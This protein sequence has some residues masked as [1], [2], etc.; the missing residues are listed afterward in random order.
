MKFFITFIL[1][2]ST[3][4]NHSQAQPIDPTTYPDVVI[5]P[6]PLI[7]LRSLQTGA[8]ISTESFAITDPRQFQWELVDVKA[9]AFEALRAG[10]SL[11][12]FRIRNTNVCFSFSQNTSCND[13]LRTTFSMIP[14]DTGA[15]ILREMELGFCLSSRQSGDYNIHPCNLKE[16]ILPLSDLWIVAPPFGEARLLTPSI[17]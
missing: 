7:T 2:I 11:V 15:V 16:A 8:P 13:H 10:G 17:K 1:T 3:L 9:S 4:W 12:Q 5:I 14:T 6:P